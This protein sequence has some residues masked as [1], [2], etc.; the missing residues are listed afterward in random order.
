MKNKTYYRVVAKHQNLYRLKREAEI[1]EARI[2]GRFLHKVQ[3]E[4]DFPVVGDW[5]SCFDCDG[6]ILI[7]EVRE[8]K[9]RI[10]RKVAGNTT[11]EQVIAANIDIVAIVLGL[12]G[13]RN[14]TDRLLER[15]LAMAWDSGA[16]PLVILNKSDLNDKAE[17]FRLQA[18]TVAPG[19]N[20]I[21][22][23]VRD[24]TGIREIYDCLAGGKVG[25]F[26]G[27][28]GVGKSALTN[29]LLQEN[30]QQTGPLRKGDKR[31]RHTT[32][33][34]VMLELPNGGNIIDSP[35][36][37]E[38][39]LWT[40]E[41]G[42]DNVFDEIASLAKD[43]KFRNCQHQGEPGCAVQR[44]L[45]RGFITPERYNSYLNLKKEIAFINMKKS[46]KRT[47]NERRKAKEFS[48]LCK[49]IQREQKFK[50]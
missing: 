39:Q 10:S 25:V 12:D 6:I 15:Y 32:S 23:S 48:K 43:C 36:L 31:G 14:Y 16:T 13:G 5:V 7:E 2:K 47:Y 38:I 18:E 17:L 20:I 35:G 42:L 37:R 26:V 44:A 24:E 30:I 45:E 21:V 40:D 33:A 49:K 19:V 27:P 50:R 46:E 11:E 28:S 3:K 1:R 4:G 22:S 29:A 9:T 34:A 8:R 41:E